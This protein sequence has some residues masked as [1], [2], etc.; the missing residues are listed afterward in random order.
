M[1]IARD[2]TDQFERRISENK[3]QNEAQ[4]P[5][6][7]YCRSSLLSYFHRPEHHKNVEMGSV[8]IPAVFDRSGFF[9]LSFC[10]VD[11]ANLDSAT[12]GQF[13]KSAKLVG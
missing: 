9:R 7:K 8:K 6:E 13:W 1:G 4:D 2:N 3:L 12:L 5:N 11:G 10:M